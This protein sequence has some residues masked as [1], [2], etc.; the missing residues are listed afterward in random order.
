M[1]KRRIHYDHESIISNLDSKD[2]VELPKKQK[3]VDFKL[4]SPELKVAERP[5]VGL[6]GKSVDLKC[7][8]VKINTVSYLII[9]FF[10][11]KII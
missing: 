4:T 7:N 1:L 9:F 3:A 8:Y 11:K 5:D 6:R 2:D 10:Q